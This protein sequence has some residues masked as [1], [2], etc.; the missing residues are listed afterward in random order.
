MTIS[1]S[2]NMNN[3]T[4]VVENQWV[5]ALVEVVS[6]IAKMNTIYVIGGHVSLGGI[7]IPLTSRNF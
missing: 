4:R 7:W 1:G 2:P 6:S 5:R 3:E